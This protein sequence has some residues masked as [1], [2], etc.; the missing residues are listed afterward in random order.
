MSMG[1][2]ARK[3]P[4]QLRVSLG[5]GCTAIVAENR[6]LFCSMFGKTGPRP[7]CAGPEQLVHTRG[8]LQAKHQCSVQSRSF[9]CWA[10]FLA[11]VV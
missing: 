10:V 1:T 8:S 11:G 2:G 5:P 9:A 3:H 4:V 6:V 7:M